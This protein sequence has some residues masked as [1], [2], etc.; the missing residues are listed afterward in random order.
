MNPKLVDEALKIVGNPNLLTNIVS[1]RVRQLCREERPLVEVKSVSED[2]SDIALR[3]IIEGKLR[4]RQA[5]QKR[6]A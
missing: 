2:F 1:L 5:P 6:A 4:W 3:E